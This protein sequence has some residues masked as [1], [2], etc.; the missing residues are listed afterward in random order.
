[1]IYVKA[2]KQAIENP[3]YKNPTYYTLRDDG[4]FVELGEEVQRSSGT[5]FIRS[6]ILWG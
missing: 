6:H 4:I 3:V 1:M 2:K 5:E